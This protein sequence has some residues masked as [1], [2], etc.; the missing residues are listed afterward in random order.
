MPTKKKI[1]Y[2]V[3]V[4][5]D[6]NWIW[7]DKNYT[8][9]EIQKSTNSQVTIFVKEFINFTDENSKSQRTGAVTL[10]QVGNDC[11]KS[12]EV[13]ITQNKTIVTRI[14]EIETE[15]IKV[16]EKNN[17]NKEP[18]MSIDTSAATEFTY[19]CEYYATGKI[20]TVVNGTPDESSSSNFEIKLNSTENWDYFSWS[21]ET[22]S[23]SEITNLDN[24]K[25]M[26]EGGGEW[27]I[28]AH[29]SDEGK[30]AIL[31]TYFCEPQNDHASG[32][33][34]QRY[35]EEYVYTLNIGDLTYCSTNLDISFKRNN[36]PLGEN[37]YV[38]SWT[39]PSSSGNS[40]AIPVNS[41]INPI[42]YTV[43]VTAT[44]IEGEEQSL[45]KTVT[46]PACPADAYIFTTNTS[47]RVF[48]YH[49]HGGNLFNVTSAFRN[50]CNGNNT[51]INIEYGVYTEDNVK[52]LDE[53]F[54]LQ[55]RMTMD[56]MN[57]N[58]V[59][60]F[61]YS[62]AHRQPNNQNEPRVAYIKIF[63]GLTNK[64]ISIKISQ[65]NGE[66]VFR[67]AEEPEI[68]VII[69]W[70]CCGVPEQSAITIDAVATMND[71]VLNKENINIEISGSPEVG[72][73]VSAIS[74]ETVGNNGVI[75]FTIPIPTTEEHV[76]ATTRFYFSPVLNDNFKIE[77][78]VVNPWACSDNI[79]PPILNRIPS[80][81]R[82]N[83]TIKN[84]ND[85]DLYVH[86]QLEY[87]EN[88]VLIDTRSLEA[89]IPRN[90]TTTLPQSGSTG[91]RTGYIGTSYNNKITNYYYNCR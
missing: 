73:D 46:Q 44:D 63:Q 85:F 82:I 71:I 59:Y 6:A 39:T 5:D 83:W 1:P 12:T 49:E 17:K 66:I 65:N 61:D 80:Q 30:T 16:Y 76:T 22:V 10:T 55:L 50:D 67:W 78:I 14:G 84:E 86:Y 9:K 25:F 69:S 52:V 20:Y 87:Y 18:D 45:T 43:T 27:N 54:W 75:R 40:K 81:E 11:G 3:K 15:S 28:T 26:V 8:K 32:N 42:V 7:L 57:N 90:S 62:V 23:G 24:G 79:I 47:D 68:P 2:S 21:A 35:Q 37:S 77:L 60:Q 91:Q 31:H 51:A 19:I 13:S 38:V 64:E 41:N 36:V 48:D 58:G 74:A 34:K 70:D 29:I 53:T 4:N 33:V 72:Y 89:P 56:G 88:G